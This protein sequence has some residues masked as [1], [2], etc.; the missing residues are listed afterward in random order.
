MNLVNMY[1]WLCLV[2]LNRRWYQ[3]FLCVTVC[4]EASLDTL[5]SISNDAELRMKRAKAYIDMG[6]LGEAISDVKYVL[7]TNNS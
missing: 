3:L 2:L 4:V 7:Y 5:Q 6:Q 1:G